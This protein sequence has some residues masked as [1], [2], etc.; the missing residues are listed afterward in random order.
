MVFAALTA[1]VSVLTAGHEA[2]E[3]DG[4]AREEPERAAGETGEVQ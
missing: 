2:P 1:V 3:G 4:A